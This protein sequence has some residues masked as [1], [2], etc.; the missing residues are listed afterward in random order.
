MAL[1]QSRNGSN[2]FSLADRV[3]NALQILGGT[4]VLVLKPVAQLRKGFAFLIRRRPVLLRGPDE[5]VI[6]I[7]RIAHHPVEPLMFRRIRMGGHIA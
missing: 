6:I 1:N 3:D 5:I 7:H 2:P 4:I